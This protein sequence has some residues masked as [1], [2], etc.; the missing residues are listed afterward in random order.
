M[1]ID[2]DRLARAKSREAKQT[3]RANQQAEKQRKSEIHRKKLEKEL[4][5]ARQFLFGKV[6]LASLGKLSHDEKLV[7]RHLVHRAELTDKEL[8]IIPEFAVHSVSEPLSLKPAAVEFAR[9]GK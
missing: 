3:E 6:I 1:S 8:A 9:T 7:I 2:L 5:T 4:E